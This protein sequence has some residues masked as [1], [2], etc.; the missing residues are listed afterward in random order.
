[1]KKACVIAVVFVCLATAAWGQTQVTDHFSLQNLQG[2]GGMQL[3]DGRNIRLQVDHFEQRNGSFMINIQA[4]SEHWQDYEFISGLCAYPQNVPEE[5]VKATENH[6]VIDIPDVTKITGDFSCNGTYGD[7]SA[8][9]Q[10]MPIKAS[11]RKTDNSSEKGSC[12]DHT[13]GEAMK[14]YS[15][16]TSGYVT[17]IIEGNVLDGEIDQALQIGGGAYIYFWSQ[18]VKEIHYDR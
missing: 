14:Y 17:A 5:Y 9:P 8:C 4:C 1:M 6:I 13:R 2:F 3:A 12:I 11:F 7:P 16:G 10:P 15:G 18:K